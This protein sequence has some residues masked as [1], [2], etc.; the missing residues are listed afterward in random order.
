M[1][2]ML[3]DAKTKIKSLE[4]E[5]KDS[6]KLL[7]EKLSLERELK[8]LKPELEHLRAQAS[9][10]QTK[11]VL[12]DS[13][14]ERLNTQIRPEKSAPMSVLDKVAEEGFDENKDPRPLLVNMGSIKPTTVSIEDL[15]PKKKKRK[16]LGGAKTIFDEDEG[17]GLKRPMKLSLA[18]ARPLGKKVAGRDKAVPPGILGAAAV[19]LG[20]FSPLKKDRRGPN[21]SF[22][23]R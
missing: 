3:T 15:E 21:A 23:A 18:S 8:T 7:A 5:S 11:R 20:A 13:R 16:V 4:D 22:L 9:Q 1:S 17:E 14:K 19:T 6:A 10:Q 2:T 12:S